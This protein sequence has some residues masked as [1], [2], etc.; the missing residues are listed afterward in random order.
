M[1]LHS[2]RVADHLRS[3]MLEMTAVSKNYRGI[4]AVRDVSFRAGPGQVIGL[5][6]PNGSGKSTTVKMLVGLLRPTA[7]TAYIGGVD[8]WREPLRAKALMGVLPEQLNLYDRL[9]G[10]E[11][12][13]FA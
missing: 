8:V 1:S 13:E 2:V 3:A 10:R 9:T 12:I 5:L 6:G 11:L 7:G 4:P